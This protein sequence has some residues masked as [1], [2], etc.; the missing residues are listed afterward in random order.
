MRAH[1]QFSS[2]KKPP[3]FPSCDGSPLAA[4][5]T[6][7]DPAEEALGSGVLKEEWEAGPEAIGFGEMRRPCWGTACPMDEPMAI[8]Q[9][10]KLRPLGGAAGFGDALDR[11]VVTLQGPRGGHP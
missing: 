4:Q 1:A 3:R 7:E 9:R 5:S 11:L 6:G 2:G 10:F 8:M